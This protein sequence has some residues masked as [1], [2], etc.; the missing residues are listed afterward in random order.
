MSANKKRE[1][2]S[3]YISVTRVQQGKEP[4]RGLDL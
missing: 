2:W 1:M 3:Q 4:A